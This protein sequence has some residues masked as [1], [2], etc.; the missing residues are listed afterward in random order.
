MSDAGH[1]RHFGRAPQR[2]AVSVSDAVSL[3][4]E[5]EMCVEV[6][7]V[8]RLLLVKRLDARSMDR[9]VAAKRDGQRAGR[10]GLRAPLFRR[11]R[12][13]PSCRYAPYRHRRCRRSAPHRA[14]GKRH[15]PLV[16]GAAVAERKERRRFADCSRD[17]NAR[18]RGTAC[19]CRR[20]CRR[21]PTSAS[22]AFQSR[23][24]RLLAERA[25]PHKREVESA[26]LRSRE[27]NLVIAPFL[28]LPCFVQKGNP[29]R[30]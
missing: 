29:L 6:H 20:G 22:M 10:P 16:V 21:W 12:G 23:Q 27:R 13:S 17:Q 4:D 11:W 24:S 28:P 8:N 1:V 19:P 15:R 5:V 25:V 26:G 7:D 18:R 14:A 2:V 30:Y 3:I 9:V